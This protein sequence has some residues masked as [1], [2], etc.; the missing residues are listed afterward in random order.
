ALAAETGLAAQ[1]LLRNERVG[2]RRSSVNLVVHEMVQLQHVDEPDGHLLLESFPGS[3]VVEEGLAALRDAGLLQA[4]AN[5]LLAGPV[6]H[7]RDRFE[8]ELL[9][10]PA[11]V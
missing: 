8:A 11:E 2:T 6:E 9:R 3:A 5:L 4:L 1:R 10:R 7:G